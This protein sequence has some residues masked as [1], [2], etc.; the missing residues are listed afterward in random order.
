MKIKKNVNKHFENFIH[1]WNNKFYFIVGGYGS[2]KSYNVALKIIL[3]C[4]QEKRKIL[5]VREV[6]ATIK[7]SCFSLIL[8]ILEDMELSKYYSYTTSP[9]KIKFTNGSE[10]IFRGCD[11]PEKLKSLNGVSMC[12]VEEA[13]EIKYSA[14]KE[15]LGRLRTLDKTLHVLMSMNPVS[16]KNWTYKHFISNY[17]IDENELYSNKKIIKNNCYYHHSNVDDNKYVNSEYKE[18]LEEIK[19]YDPDLYRIAR[20]GYFGEVGEKVF[21]TVEIVPAT[22]IKDMIDNISNNDKIVRYGM[23]FGFVTSYNALG[24][25]TIDHKEKILYIDYEYYKKGM[26]DD[27][28]AEEISQFKNVRIIAESAE[29][30]A[31]AYYNQQGFNF[32]AVSKGKVID[33]IKKI[34]RFKKIIISDECPN[35]FREF[36]ELAHKKNKDD[37]IIE[38]KY[39][40]DPHTVDMVRYALEGYEV[41]DLKG[42][43]L[44]AI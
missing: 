37:D 31:I 34:K 28:T 10:I 22:K 17:E 30:K 36:S 11:K 6:Y 41:S 29:P 19:M 15:I 32:K 42:N 33:G 26:T 20:L 44:R 12:W 7:E 13:N 24:R 16:K 40:I 1:D 27:K 4:L 38:D 9:L 14:F 21:N 8:E 43:S 23:D 35:T 39:N 5:V 2:S 25:L 18:Q 3:K